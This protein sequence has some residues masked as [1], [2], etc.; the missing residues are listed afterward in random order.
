MNKLKPNTLLVVKNRA[1]GDSI[2]GLSTLQYLRDI[3]PNTHII[4]A[5]PSWIKPLYDNV[6]TAADEIIEINLKTLSDFPKLWKNL[7]Q[8]KIDT[9]FELFQS[10]RTQKF[11]K[12]WE[13]VGGPSYV[14]HNHHN[15]QGPVFDQGIIKSNIQ[16]DIDG[17]WTFFD[18]VNEKPASYLDYAPKMTVEP[19]SKK[20]IVVGVVATRETKMWPIDNYIELTNKLLDTYP[21]YEVLIPLGPTDQNIEESLKVITNPRCKIVKESL[22]N[23]PKLLAGSKLYIGNDTGIK[24]ICISLGVKSYTLFGPEP[25]LEWHPYN[26][27]EHSYYFREP[28]ECR[29]INAHYCGLDTCESM[30]CLNTFT[31][32]DLLEKVK[33][34]LP[35]Q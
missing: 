32:N 17:A 3:L 22:S 14:A 28:L 29:T 8:Y 24:H 31:A 16:R 30:I 1:M 12:I 35:S 10:G 26:T 11:F 2:I 25:P 19:L 15:K 7:K 18:D 5:V 33:N 6:E 20:Q 13:K 27:E 34:Y 21:E 23:L 9:V 4:Y